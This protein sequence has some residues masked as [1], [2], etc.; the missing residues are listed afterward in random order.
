[1]PGRRWVER[2]PSAVR[3]K[4][5]AFRVSFELTTSGR[6]V[7]SLFA[8]PGWRGGPQRCRPRNNHPGA[9][10]NRGPIR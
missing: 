9:R 6:G 10:A 2:Y 1:M 7:P 5:P 8:D 4:S 3:S